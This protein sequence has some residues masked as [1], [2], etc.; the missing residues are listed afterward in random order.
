MEKVKRVEKTTT[1]ILDDEVPRLP[2][3]GGGFARASMGDYGEKAAH[4]VSRFASETPASTALRVLQMALQPFQSGAVTSIRKAWLNIRVSISRARLDRQRKTWSLET[5][6]RIM[7]AGGGRLVNTT[8]SMGSTLFLF[9][10]LIVGVA[11]LCE[12]C[13]LPLGF[14]ETASKSAAPK[15]TDEQIIAD[16][17]SRMDRAAAEN[18]FSGAV[19]VA[20]NGKI[21]FEHAYGLADR[22]FNAPNKLDTKFNLGSMGKMFTAVS[23][24]QLA[25]E[26][27]LSLNDTLI[28]YLPDYPDKDI[29]SKITIH[30]LLTHT[31][32]L[33]DMFN[34]KF[35]HAAK[36]E[37]RT[38]DTFLPFFTG[39]PL[40]FE[41]GSKWS[42]SNSGYILLGLVIEHVSGESYQDYVR[43]HVFRPAGMINTDNYNIDD[44]IPNL[45]LGYT[46]MGDNM[47]PLPP[48]QVRS[49][50]F[51]MITRGG[52]AG[53]GYSTVE[54]LLR[55]SQALQG[56]KLLNQQYTDLDMTGKVLE[57]KDGSVKYAYGLMDDRVNGVRIV[58]HSGGAPGV[59][60]NL[61]MYPDLGYTV[62]I[63]SNIDFGVF[64]PN[65]I[66]QLELTGQEIPP[67]IHLPQDALQA[68][69]GRYD[70]I[71][72]PDAPAGMTMPPMVITADKE[73]LWLDIGMKRRL[74]PFS[75]TEFFDSEI[76]GIHHIFTKDEKGQMT[77]TVTGLGH[78]M[79][80]IKE[81]AN[82]AVEAN[83]SQAE[84]PSPGPGAR[85]Y[86]SGPGGAPPTL[87]A[88]PSSVNKPQAI[89]L[90]AEVLKSF[91]GQYT[92]V[93]PGGTEPPPGMPPIDV[94]ADQEGLVVTFA[95]P[96]KFL[97]LSPLEFFNVE[98]PASRLTFTKNEK[99]QI[100]GF[101]NTGLS[102]KS[103]GGEDL[104]G[105]N[106]IKATKLP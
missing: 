17:R 30:Q 54:D 70:P 35:M 96:H 24:L 37:H 20:K 41:P 6:N 93:L 22:A 56:H 103:A 97:P 72:P 73:G 4:E 52:S 84:R 94:K 99:G 40:D 28:K 51:S 42:Y 69:A 61:D 5:S 3:R 77:M 78:P 57:N 23:I 11:L 38:L 63:M 60:S 64:F 47:Q 45:A 82:Q 8:R 76:L 33:P 89:H 26:G 34:D 105:P 101:T 53:G 66:L 59:S 75:P 68:F 50:V 83:P 7:P 32:G 92:P 25:Q 80:A 43:E 18:K 14:S 29:A 27:K 9:G 74:L 79:K 98:N 31:S 87:P 104:G 21:L 1:L 10:K 2:K 85:M 19:L 36:D 90:P 95:E 39:Q 86:G 62:A 100:T 91:V 88:A 12:I 71:R 55:F 106:E 65:S 48:G 15:M 58:G 49:S 46:F 13:A 16:L 44:N 102:T 67:A 81:S